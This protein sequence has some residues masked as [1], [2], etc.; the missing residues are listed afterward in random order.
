M[1]RFGRTPRGLL[2][3]QR[4]ENAGEDQNDVKTAAVAAAVSAGSYT[5]HFLSDGLTSRPAAADRRRR[6]RAGHPGDEPESCGQ[7]E[8]SPQG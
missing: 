3:S 4:R 7:S 6:V 5:L 8:G 2:E 1:E